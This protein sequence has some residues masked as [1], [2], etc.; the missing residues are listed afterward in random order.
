MQGRFVYTPDFERRLEIALSSERL[1]AYRE[2]LAPD[3]PFIDVIS[4]YNANTAASEAL[5]GPIQI[6]E[7]SVRNSIHREISNRYGAD[8]YDGNKLGLD[9]AGNRAITRLIGHYGGSP[10]LATPAALAAKIVSEL[11]LGFWSNLFQRQYE[12][13]LWRKCLRQAFPHVG[14]ALTRG[15]VYQALDRVRR[16]RNR[17]GHH[18]QIVRYDLKLHYNGIIDLVSW[19]SPVTAIWLSHHNRF[20]DVMDAY[21]DVL[22]LVRR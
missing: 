6:M 18:E 20:Y 10:R 17:I 3:A 16:L 21:R 4:V 15:D 19:V 1:G 14:G 8:W 5:M 22:S 2:I 12:D 13:P 7:I 9:R 11:T